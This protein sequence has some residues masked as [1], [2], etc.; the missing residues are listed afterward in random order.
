MGNF[1]FLI[2]SSWNFVSGCIKNVHIHHESFS[3]E[4]QVIKKLTTKNPLTTLY[5][6]N[7]TIYENYLKDA[8]NFA[9]KDFL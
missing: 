6:M 9:G 8:F 1:S 2:G 7:S 4:K 5:E 3:S